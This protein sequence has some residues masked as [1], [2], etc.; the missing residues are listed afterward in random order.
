MLDSSRARILG[1]LSTGDLVLDVGGWADPFER[2]DW[3]IDLLPYE[4]R[5]LYGSRERGDERFGEDTWVARDICDREPWPFADGQFDFAICSHTL[6]DVR[7]PVW[8]CRE[9]MRVARAGYVETPSRLEEQAF[10]VQGP[11]VGWGHH[12]WLV[13]RT[14]EGLAFVFKHHILHARPDMQVPLERWRSATPEERTVSLWWQGSFEVGER[15]FVGP[16]EIDDYLAEVAAPQT[17]SRWRRLRE[18]AT[19]RLR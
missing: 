11:W 18:R 10:G 14:D 13:D 2:A 16:G 4:T 9:L 5:G 6:E 3:V 7:D 15:V 19:A 17:G 8:V 12:H 1:Q